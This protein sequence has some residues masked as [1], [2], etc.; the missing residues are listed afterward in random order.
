MDAYQLIAEITS[1]K[2]ETC[3]E[4]TLLSQLDNWDS[5]K[6]V[7]LVIRL[8]DVIGRQLSEDEIG[9]LRSIGDVRRLMQPK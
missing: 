2:T 9:M 4:E 6:G 3:S 5:L 1:R 8:E 7:R